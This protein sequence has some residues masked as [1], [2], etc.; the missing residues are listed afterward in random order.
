MQPYCKFCR[1]LC[2]SEHHEI[3]MTRHQDGTPFGHFEC[4]DKAACTKRAAPEPSAVP[5]EEP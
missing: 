3:P 4:D 2:I 1:S 5:K